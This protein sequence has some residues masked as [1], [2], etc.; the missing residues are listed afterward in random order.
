[1]GLEVENIV[2]ST[3]SGRI[4]QSRSYCHSYGRIRWLLYQWLCL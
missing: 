4:I 3:N 1:L 2:L